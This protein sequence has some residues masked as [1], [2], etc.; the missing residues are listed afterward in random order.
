MSLRYLRKFGL[1][2]AAA[3]AVSAAV[4]A[5]ALAAPGDPAGTG[6]FATWP[7]AQQ[8][9][10]FSLL[11]PGTT[12]GLRNIGHIVVSACESSQKKRTVSAYYGSIMHASLSLTQNN[13][14]HTCALGSF[15]GTFLGT[16]RIHGI[17]ASM[18]GFCGSGLEP[19][20]TSTD[21][22]LWLNWKAKGNYYTASSHDESRAR[23]VHFAAT[24]TPATPRKKKG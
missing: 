3:M 17:K 20:C 8:E 5:P 10:G 21:I 7:K 24:L 18:F 13:A 6:M 2:A 19:A 9:A 12:Y 22:E 16:Y 1:P 14:G 11:K 23:L 4:A 15:Q